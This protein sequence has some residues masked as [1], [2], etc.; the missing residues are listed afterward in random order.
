MDNDI[1]LGLFGLVGAIIASK[2]LMSLISKIVDHFTSKAETATYIKMMNFLNSIQSCMKDIRV[3]TD[4]TRVI[5]F[6][7]HNGGG[8]PRPASRYYTTAVHWEV[9]EDY[10]LTMAD[11][12]N[13]PVDP[14]Y[15]TMLIKAHSDDFYRFQTATE[16]PSQ[17]KR[18][19]EM[20]GVTDSF[21]FFLDVHEHNFIYCSVATT[22]EGGFSNDDA[23]VIE[24]MCYK[25]KE[26]TKQANKINKL[27]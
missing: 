11:Y 19:Y 20:E 1:V 10:A 9:E 22:K 12:K 8:L 3:K 27:N 16:Q 5:I 17:L 21:V 7:G 4:A 18:I 14:R 25:L 13:I 15:I 6:A 23:T 2:P 26:L 24:V